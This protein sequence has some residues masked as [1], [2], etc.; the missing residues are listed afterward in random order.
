MVYTPVTADSSNE[1]TLMYTC[2]AIS[3]Q[4]TDVSTAATTRKGVPRCRARRDAGSS[5]AGSVIQNHRR[6]RAL[7]LACRAG[8]LVDRIL[9]VQR[10]SAPVPCCRGV[11]ASM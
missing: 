2:H 7:Q 5:A 3:R 6:P 8:K 4:I 9:L 10:I 1:S 11:F